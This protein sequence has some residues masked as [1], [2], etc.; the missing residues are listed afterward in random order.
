VT[1]RPVAPEVAFELASVSKGSRRFV[2]QSTNGAKGT[3]NIDPI[4]DR[5]IRIDWHTTSA[6]GGPALT[7]G[8]ATLVRRQ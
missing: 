6:V 2:W 4:D 8:T 3:L 1:D 7:S 5:T